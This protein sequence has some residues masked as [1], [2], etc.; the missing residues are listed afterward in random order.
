MNAQR[1]FDLA[2]IK[3]VQRA[4][5]AKGEVVCHINQRRNRAQA[6]G[7]QPL[8]QP[9]GRGAI[10]HARDGAACKMWAAFGLKVSIN[11]N[12]DG[13]GEAALDHSRRQRFQHAQ[14]PRGKVARHTAHSQG[15]GAIG[16]DFDVDHRV[17]RGGAVDGQPIDKAVPNCARRQFDD[18]VMLVRQFQLALGCHHPVAFH[19][20]DFA[21]TQGHVDARHIIARFAQND[22]DAF[23][24]VRCTANDLL[25]ALIRQ[26]A[27]DAQ[28]VGIGMLFGVDDLG[29]GKGGQL[30]C[31]VHHLFNL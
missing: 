10:F 29:Q 3:H 20:A 24:R 22:R 9:I 13:R 23:A 7:F 6:D 26:H 8:L 21:H 18:A 12:R 14:T 28:F 19:A 31:W 30:G 25:F 2:G 1:A 5:Q 16:G 15:I 4:V 17:N 27:A 11:R